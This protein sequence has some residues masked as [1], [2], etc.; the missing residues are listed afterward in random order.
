MPSETG[1]L[2]W[3]SESIVV[4]FASAPPRCLTETSL[5]EIQNL[6][7]PRSV[8]EHVRRPDV[9]MTSPWC[10]PCPMHQQFRWRRGE[11]VRL[12]ADARVMRCFSV[13]PSKNSIATETFAFYSPIRNRANIGMVQSGSSP[14]LAAEAFH[15]C[16]SCET[17]SEKM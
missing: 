10:V 9:A 2:R 7:C 8:P 13:S 17:S 15:A 12:P 14:S 1:T 11:D 4:A 5:T 16:G 6:A 3:G